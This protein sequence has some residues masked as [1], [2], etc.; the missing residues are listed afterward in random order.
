MYP[1]RAE[2]LCATGERLQIAAN[3]GWHLSGER[4]KGNVAYRVE[5][6]GLASTCIVERAFPRLTSVTDYDKRH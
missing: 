1:W 6:E 5:M 2:A 3:A 4:M